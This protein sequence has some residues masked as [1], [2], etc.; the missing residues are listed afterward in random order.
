MTG[1]GANATM[2]SE[3]LEA[4]GL[5]PRLRHF[6]LP[7]VSLC[8]CVV[9]HGLRGSNRLSV[10]SAWHSHRARQ[11]G[12]GQQV[13]FPVRQAGTLLPAWRELGKNQQLGLSTGTPRRL[14]RSFT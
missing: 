13:G 12:R 5:M 8:R 9:W 10:V 1:I 4:I 3:Y 7:C 6:S 2:L 11:R 14:W